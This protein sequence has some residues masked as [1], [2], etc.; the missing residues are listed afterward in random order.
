MATI[1]TPRA[2]KASGISAPVSMTSSTPHAGVRPTSCLA[3]PWCLRRPGLALARLG[4]FNL[5]LELLHLALVLHFADAHVL[6]DLQFLLARLVP[7]NDRDNAEDHQR[8]KDRSPD[9][10]H[11]RPQNSLHGSP[12]A[13]S[14]RLSLPAS[15]A[16]SFVRK[17]AGL[18]PSRVRPPAP[19]SGADAPFPGYAA[20]AG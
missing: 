4:F 19:S 13:P 16:R 14:G 17:L 18:W 7:E 5:Q 1:K 3:T 20:P 2:K 6:M 15:P 12:R 10:N 11:L 8:A 9:G